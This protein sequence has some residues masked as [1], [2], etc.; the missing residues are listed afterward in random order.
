MNN[1]LKR[2]SARLEQL[3]KVASDLYAARQSREMGPPYISPESYISWCMTARTV[4]RQL[5][6]GGHHERE[7]EAISSRSLDWG[8]YPSKL[9][10]QLGIMRALK[11]DLDGGHLVDL[12]GLIRAEVFVD[13]LEQARH[14]LDQGYWQAVPVIIGAVLEDHLRKLCSKYPSITLHAKPKLDTMNAE[15]AKVGEYGVL[16]QKQMTVWADIRNKAAHGK[17]AE[18]KDADVEAML[19]DV[20][21][22]LL[23]HPM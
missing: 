22:F 23:D 7:F 9:Q 20:P 16:E 11:D 8:G 6:P 19:R 5:A 17:W 10:I 21:R 12:H 14:L 18:F 3:I 2:T 13:F 4:L 15:L 1:A